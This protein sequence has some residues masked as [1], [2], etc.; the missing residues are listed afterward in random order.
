MLE[1]PV[2]EILNSGAPDFPFCLCWANE[3]WTRRWD[4]LHREV[5][6]AQQYTADDDLAHIR[7][8]IRFFWTAVT[9]A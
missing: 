7:S 9:F 4:G 2:N 6:L 3:N 5:L 8:L 1:R